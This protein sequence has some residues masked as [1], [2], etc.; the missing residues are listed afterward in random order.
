MS[1]DWDAVKKRS[2]RYFRE[3]AWA[4]V[5]SYRAMDRAAML[6]HDEYRHFAKGERLPTFKALYRMR[7]NL[8]K[9]DVEKY[10]C[11]VVDLFE[12]E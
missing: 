1:I 12:E 8:R 4:Y 7:K 2:G 3:L 6:S 10:F 11:E 5:R 9:F